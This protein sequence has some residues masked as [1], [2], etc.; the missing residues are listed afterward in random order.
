V[1]RVFLKTW[2]TDL[3]LA[4]EFRHESWETP[5][6]ARLLED[7]GVAWVWADNCALPDQKKSGFGFLPVTAK[8]LYV[9]LLGDFRTK[10]GPDGKETHRYGNLLWSRDV[11]LDHWAAKLRHHADADAIYVFANNHFEG[12]A[13][14]TVDRLAHRIG[15]DLPRY[16]ACPAQLDLFGGTAAG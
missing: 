8:H 12:M 10:Y 14:E 13:V 4:I 5:H 11:S 9:R 16:A 1:L 3:P 15:I 2:P 6:A 7:H